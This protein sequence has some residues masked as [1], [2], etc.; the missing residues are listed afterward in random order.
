MK[1]NKVKEKEKKAG[2]MGGET[3]SENGL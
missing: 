2:S 3:H 1:A